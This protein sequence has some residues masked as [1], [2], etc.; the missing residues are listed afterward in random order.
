M[1]YLEALSRNVSGGHR[2]TTNKA[3]IVDVP[4]YIRNPGF[5][6]CKPD[7]LPLSQTRYK[8]T[9]QLA[10]AVYVRACITL[11]QSLKTTEKQ[12]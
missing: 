2:K 6:E 7:G 4:T 9:G 12:F 10:A 8:Y 5:S 1:A 11:Q 3:R